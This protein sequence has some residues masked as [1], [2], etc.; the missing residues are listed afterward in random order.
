[1]TVSDDDE[2]ENQ[3]FS[4]WLRTGDGVEYMKVFVMCNTLMVVLTMAWPQ[5]KTAVTI[6][7]EYWNEQ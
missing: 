1:V 2:E 4:G 7:M 3:G 5:L 6:A